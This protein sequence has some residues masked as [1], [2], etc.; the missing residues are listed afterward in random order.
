MRR[1]VS[2]AENV[3]SR[4]DRSIFSRYLRSAAMSPGTAASSRRCKLY[5]DRGGRQRIFLLLRCSFLF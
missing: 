1:V 5:Q 3:Q 4:L 2:L